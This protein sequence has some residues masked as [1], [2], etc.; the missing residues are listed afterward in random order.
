MIG[1]VVGNLHP[2]QLLISQRQFALFCFGLSLL[3]K[4]FAVIT[5]GILMVHQPGPHEN[6]GPE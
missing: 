6:A 2:G 1:Y 3:S 5:A 4:Y